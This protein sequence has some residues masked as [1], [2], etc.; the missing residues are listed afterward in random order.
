MK[1]V[2]TRF[3]AYQLG[4]AGSSFSYFANGRFTLIEARLNDTNKDSVI[5]EMAL[6]G[7][8]IAHCLHITSW[9]S[10]HC[11]PSELPLVLQTLLPEKIECPGYEPSS[12]GGKE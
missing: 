8:E 2:I 11:S 12:D 5:Q 10:D 6:C 4:C 7:V 1:S 9:D 3:R